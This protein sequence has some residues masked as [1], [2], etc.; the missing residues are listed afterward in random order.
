MQLKDTRKKQAV[1]PVP[2]VLVHVVGGNELLN[3]LLAG[4]LETE[5][6]LSCIPQARFEVSEDGEA[7]IH[8]ILFDCL[9]DEPSELWNAVERMERD[10]PSLFFVA[11]F[12]AENNED[13]TREA[14]ARKARGIIYKG[15][16]L[17]VLSKGVAAILEGELWYSREVLSQFLMEPKAPAGAPP[18]GAEELTLREK[19]IL[20][21]I[22]AGE[23]NK[24]IANALFI[25]LHTVKS[26]IYNIYRK[27]GVENR[28]RAAHWAARH[29]KQG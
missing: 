23:S 21:K 8:L 12:N 16:P 10:S 9:M 18:E 28:M 13:L 6:G 2:D 5:E 22:A 27:I 17:P 20:F 29:L 4:Y 3:E 1:K 15:T 14:L 26:H 19:E 7:G 11:L 25:S 24:E